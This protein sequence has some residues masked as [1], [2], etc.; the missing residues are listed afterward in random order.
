MDFRP[1]KKP[2]DNQSQKHMK[3]KTILTALAVALLAPGALYATTATTTPVGY[4]TETLKP[5]ITNLV[6]LTVHSPTV[7]SG[8]I[9]GEASDKLT[10]AGANFTTL[11]TAGA[12]YI[13][14]LPDG[15]IQEIT[16]WTATELTTPQDVSGVVTP[17]TTVLNLR[18]A[19]TVAE[20]FGAA[21]QVGLTVST[22]G[23][24][25]ACDTILVPNGLGGF[26]TYFYYNDGVDQAWID[27]GFNFVA[28]VP[29]VYTDALL[30]RRVAGTDKDLVVTGEV[31]KTPT[32]LVAIA[33]DNYF[34]A[35]YPAGNTLDSST[36]QTQVTPSVD[37]SPVLADLILFPNGTGGFGTNL[38]YN[39]G[40]DQAWIDPGFNF[41]GPTAFTSGYLFT[42]K[43]ALKT[44][45]HVPDPTVF[46]SL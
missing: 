23:S 44:L 31:K 41:T 5:N 42:N 33:G 34:G 27:P 25:A 11:L 45:T 10:V 8:V 19:P 21:N 30:V 18:K 12:T 32:K 20:I 17:N 14:E 46:S 39:D 15:T 28:D 24:T 26:N 22:D 7:F 35:I 13:L 29:I 37:G 40:V 9:T 16:S 38:Y 36:L 3:P 1:S 6:G 2:K 4:V 43:G